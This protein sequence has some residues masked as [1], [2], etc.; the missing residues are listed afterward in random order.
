M[1]NILRYCR[2]VPAVLAF[3]VGTAL[4][5]DSGNAQPP[6]HSANQN[7]PSQDTNT[8]IGVRLTGNVQ[9]STKDIIKIIKTRQGRPFS[10][11]VLEEDKRALMQKTW[12]IDVKTTV[13]KTPEGFI[14]TFQ[15]IERPLLH[16]TKMVGNQAHTR[17]QLL[18]EANIQTGDAQDP[19][20]VHQAAER[21]QQFYHQSGYNKIHIDILSGD[22]LGD[23]G[24][25]F[26][27]DEGPKQRILSTDF[28]GNRITTAG[29]LKTIVKSKPGWFLWVN[30]EFS[31]KQLDEDVE[32]LTNYYRKLGFFYAKIDR[33]F[34]ETAGYTGWGQSRNWVKIKFIVDEGPRCKIRDIRFIGN[35]AIAKEDLLKLMKAS[36]IRD[37]YFNQ[38]MVEGDMQKIKEKYGEQGYVFAMP[39]PN[40]RVDQDFVDIVVNI[41][42]GPRCYLNTLD[43]EIVGNDNAESYTK[44]QPILNR[45]SLRPGDILSSKDINATKRRLAAAQL[46]NTN[47]TQGIV[48]EFIFDYPKEAIADETA[49]AEK[50]AEEV[51]NAERP[52]IRGQESGGN[53]PLHPVPQHS[54]QG[55]PPKPEQKQT[56]VQSII[57][58]QTPYSSQ[59]YGSIAPA[60]MTL[61]YFPPSQAGSSTVSNGTAGQYTDGAA[62]YNQVSDA[63]YKVAA[64]D[65]G[66]GT[67][68]N[69]TGASAA[70]PAPLYLSNPYSSIDSVSNVRIDPNAPAGGSQ[71]IYPADGK[72]RVQETRTGNMMMSVAVSSDA[73]LMGRFVIEEQNFDILNYPKGFRLVDWKNAFRGKG[74]RMRIEA[75]PGT[76]IQRYSVGWETP[77]FFDLDYSFGVNGFYY[78]R[79]YDEWHENRL[80]G[81]FS[82]GKLWT[83]D[84]ST[85]LSLGGQE[86]DI[87]NPYITAIQPYVGKHPMY[88]I[89]L[90]ATHNTRDSEFMPTEGHLISAGA[91]Q[92]L[93]DY[94]FLRGNIDLRKYFMLRERP[95]R[96]GRWVLGLRSSFAVAEKKAPVYERYFGGGFTSLRGFDFRGVS[97]RDVN[98]QIT[99]GCMEFYNSAEMIF[100]LTADD[101]VRGSLFVDTGTVESS[102]SRWHDEYRVAVGFGLRLTIPMMG[103]A[104]I[105]LDFAFPISKAPGDERQVFSFNMGFMR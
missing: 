89:G 55:V 59:T 48:P 81:A 56:A 63:S 87:R 94:Q 67:A 7:K 18:E 36:S 91:E 8:V 74:Q 3:W 29:R 62:L 96:S 77:Y 31:R 64:A 35:H 97:P 57:R 13:E 66:T 93:G 16:Y 84:F 20:A 61:D 30:S 19:I 23:R 54:P 40:P 15:F 70:S 101:M 12:F 28:E 76:D 41:K 22:A 71:K 95:D 24:A 10:E 69:A 47:P 52:Q 73:G 26:L 37:K 53:V 11:T 86:V 39:S 98:G 14:V 9:V 104:P 46:F 38:D 44:W 43:I 33:T 17:Q 88:T 99:G 90:D 49:A 60:P 100:P 78:Q 27:I 34:E 75:A 50:E 65:S 92:V 102:L 25:V 51:L 103:P 82:F 2:I 45:T 1:Q 5:T 58:G 83:P 105:A 79:Y 72:I 6:A 42:E 32:A 85:K 68:I 21:M 80:G 4:W